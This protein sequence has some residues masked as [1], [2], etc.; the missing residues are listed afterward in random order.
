MEIRFDIY[1]ISYYNVVANNRNLSHPT[2]EMYIGI[3][4]KDDEREKYFIL[5]HKERKCLRL[6]AFSWNE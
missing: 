2:I 3:L 1:N 5:D 4:K 6:R